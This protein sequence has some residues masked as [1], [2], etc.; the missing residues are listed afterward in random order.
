M[1]RPIRIDLR[2]VAKATRAVKSATSVDDYRAAL[3]VLLPA[4]AQTSLAETATLLGVGTASVNRLQRRFRTGRTS[5]SPKR[6]WGG[7]RQ[8]LLTFED[9]QEFLR[10]WAAQAPEAGILVL[11]PIRAALA[12]RVGHPVRASVVWR[13][14]ARHG[15]RKVAPDT[16]H[17]KNNPQVMAAWKKNF[18]K[19]WR[20][21]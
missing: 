11:S 1:A 4:T 19:S 7:R 6:N 8:S 5:A 2:L 18:R 3:A 12:Q 13:L 14:L 16:R 20:P 15:W 10:P 9:E 17:P 21:F